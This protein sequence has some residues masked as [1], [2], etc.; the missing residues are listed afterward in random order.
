MTVYATL[1][2]PLGELLLVGEESA[3]APGGTALVSLSVPGQKGGAVV[4]DGWR[5]APEAFD[6]IAAQ[7][8][9]YFAGE[10]TRF[11]I[12]Y[13]AGA[14]GTD[15]QRQVWA[16]LDAIEY[17]TTVSYGEIARRLGASS[18]LVRAVGT[19]IGRNPLLVV[20]PCHRVIGSD[21]SLKG[22][23]GGLERKQTLLGLEGAP[24]S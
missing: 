20:R 2:S 21:G 17:G 13:A 18:V 15:F 22:Y 11:D 10:L 4:R 6:G 16:E 9:A 7:L 12:E 19:A 14:S 24:A 3:T 23:A 1:E 8:R 5:H